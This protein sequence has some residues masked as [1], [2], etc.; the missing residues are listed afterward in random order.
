M[1]W[2]YSSDR[3]LTSNSFLGCTESHESLSL[4]GKRELICLATPNQSAIHTS[5][6]YMVPCPLPLPG[7]EYAEVYAP[8]YNPS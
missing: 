6:L 7:E 3:F 4:E 1:L 5:S 8:S 2:G